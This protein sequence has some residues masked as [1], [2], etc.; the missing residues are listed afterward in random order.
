MNFSTCKVTQLIF[1]Y[2]TYQGLESK[3]CGYFAEFFG[4]T[5]QETSTEKSINLF[6]FVISL[7]LTY[8]TLT[9]CN[10]KSYVLQNDKWSAPEMDFCATFILSYECSN[11]LGFLCIRKNVKMLKYFLGSTNYNKKDFRLEICA[12]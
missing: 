6:H 3:L 9:F 1:L 5:F 8:H 10:A 4:K 2:H 12:F 11:F 7:T